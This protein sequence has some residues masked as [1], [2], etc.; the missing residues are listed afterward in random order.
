[1]KVGLGKYVRAY[2]SGFADTYDPNFYTSRDADVAGP[3][4]RRHRAGRHQL[5]AERHTRALRVSH[6]RAAKSTS[7]RCPPPSAPSRRRTSR[8]TSSG[9]IRSRRTPACSAKSMPGTSV[10]FSYFRRDYKNLIWSRQHRASIRPTTP[11]HGADPHDT[12]RRWTIYNL[13]P[14]KAT[15]VEPARSATRR[16]LP[17]I[18]RLRRQLQ[19]PDEGADAVRRHQRRAIRFRTPA[20]SRIRTSSVSAIRPSYGHPDV[21]RSSS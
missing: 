14:A 20:R 9:R 6:G 1:M 4:Q 15:R 13:N 21:Q 17:E 8:P 5:P 12:A 19:Q 16:E 7:R 11:V 3:E 18:H 10:T 2:S